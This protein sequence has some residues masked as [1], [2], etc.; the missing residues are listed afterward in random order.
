MS[1]KAILEAAG[2]GLLNANLA[3]AGM[4]KNRI[5]T[6]NA[7]TDWDFLVASNPW[8]STERLVAKPDQLIKR[9]GKL[10]L[11]KVN[12][13]LDEVKQWVNE[14]MNKEMK[15][16]KS[17]GL[18]KNFVIEP[19]V[20]HKQEEEFY[21]CIYAHRDGETILFHHEGG[22]D[23]GDVDAKAVKLEVP[24][25][26]TPS[27]EDLQKKL[28]QNAPAPKQP[29]LAQFISNLYTVY[30]DLYFTYLEINPLVV[31]DEGVYILDLAA[32]IDQTA[33][34][35]CKAKWGELDFP[36]PFGREAYPEGCS[37]VRT[38]TFASVRTSER[39]II[40]M[41]D[42]EPNAKAHMI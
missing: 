38:A 1:A 15:I 6:V 28:V 10:G 42:G 19:F 8:M 37:D 12:A 33:E 4:V 39:L 11:I 7:E 22:V 35:I 31:T 14:R 30:T 41:S 29:V 27:L 5:A 3:G 2:K 23:I 18:L 25:G 24:I 32:K 17:T 9:R 20:P 36:P 13:T 40:N 21:V 34:F 26:E 16:G